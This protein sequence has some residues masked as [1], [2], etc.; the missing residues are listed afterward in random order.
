MLFSV[1]VPIYNIEKYLPKCIDS[2]LNQTCLD[3]EI[4]LVDDGSADNCGKICDEYSLKDK[5]IIVIHKKNSGVS[6]ARN[7]ALKIAKGDYI[8]CIDGDDWID[9]NYLQNFKEAIEKTKAD[10]ICCGINFAKEEKVIKTYPYNF[11][12]GYYNKQDIKNKIY[13]CLIKDIDGYY[14]PPAICSKV[15][16][17]ELYMPIQ[18][19]I[20]TKIKISEDACVTYSCVSKANSIYVSK[21]IYYFY[22]INQY[23]ATRNRNNGFDWDNS[24]YFKDSLLKNLDQTEYD[25]TEQ[26]NRYLC[27]A[28]F[29]IAVSHLRTNRKY[30]EV[31]SEIL[32]HFNL[33]E[34]KEIL[35]K[36][37]FKILSKDYFVQQV[38]KYNQIWILKLY[39][40]LSEFLIKK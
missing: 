37:K 17:K 19:S 7:E 11:K 6:S 16:K 29:N 38:M 4:I 25:F 26:I 34:N 23:S 27:H 24:N 35:N 18:L 22:R 20:N 39:A 1:I 30:K 12:E 31:K 15:F 21:K 28:L 36:T 13:P 3:F 32:Y 2:I 8:A 10:I 40:I 5:R 33:I 14:F 9:V